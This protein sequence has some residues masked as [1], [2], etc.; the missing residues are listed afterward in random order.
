L[1]AVVGIVI[2]CLGLFGLVSFVC[3]KRSKEVSIR[4]VLGATVSNI[5]SLLSRDFIVLVFVAFLLAVPIGWYVMDQFLSSY[6]NHVEIHWS[7]FLIA[8][9]ITLALA[10]ITAGAKSF[11]TAKMNPAQSLKNE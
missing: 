6:T 9:C 7:I 8:G 1:F 4:K 11:S 2:G 5:M 3:A 10:L